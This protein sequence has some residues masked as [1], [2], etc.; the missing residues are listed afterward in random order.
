[1][2]V[3]ITVMLLILIAVAGCVV[4]YAY[5]V[6]LI[7]SQLDTAERVERGV[8]EIVYLDTYTCSIQSGTVTLDLYL[9]TPAADVEIT[10]VYVKAKGQVVH[11]EQVSWTVTK[12]PAKFTLTFSDPS[13]N[14][15]T[16][17]LI[18][19]GGLKF[20]FVIFVRA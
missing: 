18:S 20:S 9:R 6:S 15:L 16:V 11:S 4:T 12:T 13:A 5:F 3:L 10:H 7:R 14:A 19:K 8:Q 17:V 1:M 2:H